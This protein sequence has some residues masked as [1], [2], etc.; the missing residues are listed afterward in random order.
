MT[1]HATPNLP[2]RDYDKTIKF[3]SSLGFEK[4]WHDD[5][6][7]IMKRDRLML[8]FFRYSDLNPS[9]SSFSCCLRLDDVQAFYRACVDANIPEQ[10]VG[11]PRVHKPQLEH[12]GMM[13][14]YMV[15]LDGSLLRL[16]QNT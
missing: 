13:I 12:S 7:L 10:S 1:D 14:G 15:D 8:E 2:S 16:V 5:G 4:G 3:Y 9:E 11:W 6:W